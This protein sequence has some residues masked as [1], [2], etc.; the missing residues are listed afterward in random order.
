MFSSDYQL[1]I[2]PEN[3]VD[4]INE[5]QLSQILKSINYIGD[6]EGDSKTLRFQTGDKFLSH[7]CF[8]GCS[9]DITLHPEKDKAYTYIEIPPSTGTTRFISGLN[10]KIPRCPSCKKELTTLPKQLKALREPSELIKCQHCLSLV[11]SYQLNWRRTACFARTTIIIG[12][13]Y[14]SEAVPD[15]R[16]LT[17]LYEKTGFVWKYAYVRF[18]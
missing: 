3:P 17:T 18:L 2:F 11:N 6:T 10:I 16:F 1:L 15:D 13:I 14:E 8:L 12:N 5:D 9:P 7:L 4:V